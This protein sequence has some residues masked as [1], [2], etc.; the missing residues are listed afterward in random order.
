MG[1]LGWFDNHTAKG[2]LRLAQRSIQGLSMLPSIDPASFGGTMQITTSFSVAAV[3][4]FTMALL[5]PRPVTAWEV[6]GVR[7]GMSL[8]DARAQ[9]LRRYTTVDDD[10]LAVATHRTTSAVRRN[11]SEDLQLWS[12]R[13]VVTGYAQGFRGVTADVVAVYLRRALNAR[14]QVTFTGSGK[15]SA[16]IFELAD[17]SA[18]LLMAEGLGTFSLSRVVQPPSDDGCATAR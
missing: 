7:Y 1:L 14:P 9:L 4:F 8:D 12:C 11:G 5:T 17:R 18:L 16:L 13:G 3:L 2:Q 6:E 15:V 10:A